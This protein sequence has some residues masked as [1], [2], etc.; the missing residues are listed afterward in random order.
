MVTTG[1][2]LAVWVVEIVSMVLRLIP[3]VGVALA[4]IDYC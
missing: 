2:N 4:K 3:M 1:Y